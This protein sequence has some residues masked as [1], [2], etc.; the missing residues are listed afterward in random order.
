[1]KSILK[2]VF[3]PIYYNTIR[4]YLPRKIGV[5]HSISTRRPRLFDLV[6]VSDEYEKELIEMIEH[7]TEKDDM[8][9]QVG[10]GFGVSTIT[11]SKAAGPNGEIIAYEA[12]EDRYA[13]AREA[14][15]LNSTP[16]QI[17]L[18]KGVVGENIAVKGTEV[19]H[20]ILPSELPNGDLLILD[21][22]GAEESILRG[23]VEYPNRMIIETHGCFGSHTEEIKS[24]L[25]ENGYAIEDSAV[26][27]A[28]LGIDILFAIHK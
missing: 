17:D 3:R 28:D 11:A 22:E 26:E 19:T 14:F 7:R 12:S 23:M 13:C 1:M 9:V 16:V 4:D 10:A 21:C 2:A 20:S 8:V 6:D 24:I 15:E 25:N 27:S 18:R 5:Y